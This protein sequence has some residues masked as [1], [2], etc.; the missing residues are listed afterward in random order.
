MAIHFSDEQYSTLRDTY[1]LW[2][3]GDLDRPIVTIITSGHETDVKTDATPLSFYTAWNFSVGVKEYIDAH[4]ALLSTY[5]WHGEAFPYMKTEAFG[6]GVLA[7]FLGCTPVG[8]PSTVWFKPPRENIPIEELH[9]EFD[10]NNIYYRRVLNFYE[11]AL[12]K[13]HGMVTVGMVD[14]GGIL[15]V[16]QSFRGAENLLMDL[17]DS[18]EEVLRCVNE[19]QKMWFVYYDKINDMLAPEAKGYSHWFGTYH[20]KP[21]YILQ[22][23]FSY[24]I[25]PRMFDEF[26]AP[27]LSS[28]GARMSNAVYHLDGIGELAH[29]DSILA[30]DSIKGIQWVPGS[31]YPEHQNWDEVIT[32]ILD[33]GKKLLSC[34]KK[35]DGTP[36][37]P[38][39]NRPGQ[40]YYY[41]E[42]FSQDR[43][44]EARRYG[45][46]YGIEV[47]SR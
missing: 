13:W 2:W 42:I 27:E 25:G 23:D 40:L 28:S 9:F 10:E 45:G 7:A 18:P 3:K 43:I 14:M 37:D 24:M 34:G 22:S 16:L 20:D 29:L 35:P 26:V 30:I 31:G 21:S 33:A 19:L 12:E 11:A 38:A 15:D 6:P 41:P 17:Y 4:D 44:E 5:R 47:S 36:A 32:R 46:L 8:T 1:N 39:K